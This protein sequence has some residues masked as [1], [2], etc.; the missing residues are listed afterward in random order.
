MTQG[1]FVM[2]AHLDDVSRLALEITLAAES[3][4]YTASTN[5]ANEEVIDIDEDEKM[6][7]DELYEN[8]LVEGF[9]DKLEDMINFFSP[10][11]YSI[12]KNEGLYGIEW[13]DDELS[14]Y[15]KKGKLKK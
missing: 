10:K 12:R 2:E 3:S 5:Y 9:V 14:V 13:D 6:L 4:E 15:L 7:L 1:Q 8:G 11:N